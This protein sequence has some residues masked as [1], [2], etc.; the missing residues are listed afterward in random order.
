[1]HHLLFVQQS[2][3]QQF[4]FSNSYP[5]PLDQVDGI[6]MKRSRIEVFMVPY[7]CSFFGQIQP[8]VDPGLAQVGRWGAPSLTDWKALATKPMHK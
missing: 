8:G 3:C 5:E 4:T 6:L 7:K 1:M 2:V